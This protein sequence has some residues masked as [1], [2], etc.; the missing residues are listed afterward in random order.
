MSELFV[1]RWG[2]IGR[3]LPGGA[4]VFV[5]ALGLGACRSARSSASASPNAGASAESGAS[6][7]SLVGDGDASAPDASFD[8]KPSDASVV[9]PA[10]PFGTLSRWII[11]SFGRRFKVAGVNW[12]G[13][14]S[15][16]YVPAG[17]DVASRRAIASEIRALGFNTVRLPW[18]NELFEVDPTVDSARVA[19]N[20]DLVGKDAM[21]VFD[22]VIAALAA[23][24]IAVILDNHRSDANSCCDVAHGDGLWYTPDF[25]ET[26]WI[27]DW[28]GMVE[29]YLDQ[30]A[31]VG[32]DLRNDLRPALLPGDPADCT[33]CDPDAGC[34]CAV[35][36]W[37]G[38][39]PSVDWHAA[40]ERGG[41]AVL[42][43]NPTLL[44]IVEGVAG[45]T[46]LSG[47]RALP[48]SLLVPDRLVYSVHEYA[49]ASPSF[50][51]YAAMQ[52]AFDGEWTYL[53]EQ[54]QAFTAPVLVGEFGTGHVPGD[55]A[56]ASGQGFWFQSFTKLLA[57]DD[58]DWSYWPL[59]GT[60][61]SGYS[62]TAGVADPDGLLD[63]T[64]SAPALPALQTVLRSIQPAIQ[65]PR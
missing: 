43:A 9:P 8:S 60:Q 32:V 61:A 50:P 63:V 65:G 19:A 11:D 10:A 29:R 64:W 28:A 2:P 49:A 58:V 25:P 6:D 7:A 23:E 44:V 30:P 15:Q 3:R 16:D 14:E 41:D 4:L 56:G 62:G 47:A 26:S 51:S 12:Y 52:L 27:D 59:N 39:D 20:P 1:S 45:A 34:P 33:S 5:A 48:V 36:A 18:S 54:G 38:S 31:V 17:L 55:L 35:P 40:A 13:A 53:L 42:A 57:E 24:G 46:D 37:G 22:A 21:S